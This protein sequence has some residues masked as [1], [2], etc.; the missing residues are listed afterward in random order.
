MTASMTAYGRTEETNEI[1]HVTWE[2]RTV[3]HR[4]LE[5]SIRLPE[6]LRMLEAKIREHV[7]NKLNRGKVDCTLRFDADEISRKGLSINTE[8]AKNLVQSA[9]SIQSSM[10]NP[11]ALNAMDVLR[12]PG[13]INRDMIDA[14]SI[15]VPLL[16]QLDATLEHVVE[17]RLGEGQ[18]LQA[19]I[20]ERCDSI[21]TLLKVFKEKLPEIQQM[22]RDRLT[23]KS[24]E[25]SIELDNDRLE[26]EILLLVQK[27]D[28]AEELDRL[29]AHLGE[30]RHVLQKNKP[31]GRRLD[32]LMQELNREANT[33]GSKAA[34]LDYTNTSVDLKVL[35]EQMREQIQNIE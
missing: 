21:A 16:E 4:Y 13:V 28:V 11:A 1:G 32:F 22:L 24:Q 26:Q 6:E 9:E 7:S 31:V 23:Q 33:L 14:E 25:L 20:I 19:M 5:V 2:I 17:T 27:S 15:S 35:I 8:L 29:D 10:A 18:K 3:N 12:W 34:N 30:V